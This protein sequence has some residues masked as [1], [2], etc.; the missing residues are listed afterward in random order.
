MFSRCAFSR[1][2]AACVYRERTVAISDA[3]FRVGVGVAGLVLVLGITAVRFCGSVSLP[4]KPPPVGPTG[5]QRQQLGK[6][7]ASPSVYK[8]FLSKDAS[9]A[10]VPTP[11]VDDMRKKLV[12]R[13][14]ESRH[15][16]EVGQPAIEI[17]GL[18][19][20][21]D[22][23]GDSLVL[24]IDNTTMSDLGYL[25]V[26]SVT[27]NVSGCDNAR[28]LPFNAMVLTRGG[29]ETRVECVFRPGIAIAVKRVETVELQPLSAW[30]VSLV[31]PSIVGIDERVARGH[32][33]PDRGDRCSM[34]M[35][36]AVRSGMESGEIGWR[37]LVDFYA[38]HRCATY[39]FPVSYRAFKVDG[40]RELPAVD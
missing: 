5:S 25:V 24:Q 10:G 18:K 6:S 26:T 9:A 1:T 8:D 32:Q 14:D 20:R 34:T 4:P 12:Y 7:M 28:M 15:L 40:E 16:L 29:S 27:P 39:R 30:Y 22:K 31:P 11:S 23:S 37:D 3:Q 38:R 36:Q 21:A 33:P 2:G 35:S 17:A 13:S 19:L